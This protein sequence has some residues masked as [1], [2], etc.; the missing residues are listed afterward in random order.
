[1]RLVYV[2]IFFNSCSGCLCSE[3]EPEPSG[4]GTD[5]EPGSTRDCSCGCTASG[6]QTC[7]A[8]R[9]WGQCMCEPRFSP[10]DARDANFDAGEV[11]DAS[12]DVSIDAPLPLRDAPNDGDPDTVPWV[13]ST[14]ASELANALNLRVASASAPTSDDGAPWDPDGT[15]PDLRVEVET[16]AGVVLQTSIATDSY[17]TVFTDDATTRINVGEPLRFTLR[18]IDELTPTGMRSTIIIACEPRASD[19]LRTRGGLLQCKEGDATI[20]VQAEPVFSE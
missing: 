18:D 19:E 6:E 16:T 14:D 3:D 12:R 5:C 1:M 8:T 11:A 17:S 10:P 15:P 2:M 13:P 20:E 4:C 9:A 7:L